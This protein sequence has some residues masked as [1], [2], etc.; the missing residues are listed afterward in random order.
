MPR[1]QAIVFDMDGLMVDTERLYIAS[2]H[3]IAARYGKSVGPEVLRQMMGRVPMESMGIFCRALQIEQPAEVILK[4]RDDLMEARLREGFR[5][6]PGLGELIEY[7]SGRYRLAIA[8]GSPK[9]FLDIIV[10]RLQLR[11]RFEVL[12]TSDGITQGKPHPEIYLQAMAKLGVAGE[13]CIVLEDSPNGMK[14]GR[15]AGAYVIGVPNE[16]TRDGD[17]SAAHVCVRDLHEARQHVMTLEG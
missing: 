5:T 4:Q 8:T 14:A 15:T 16:H 11:D 17:L 3:D 12:Q 6:L 13:Q 9:R 2:N 10:D 1:C 7:A